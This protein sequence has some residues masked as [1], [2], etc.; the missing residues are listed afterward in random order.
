M[1]TVNPLAADLNH[2]LNH[3]EGLWD[4]FRG[5]HIFVTGGTG[6]F[7]CWLLE[8]FV[9][10]NDKLGL[11]SQAVVLTR[12]PEVFITKAPHLAKHPAIQLLKG[13]VRSFDFPP[14][15][16]SHVIHM[17]TESSQKLNIADPLLMLDT[18]IEGTR[19]VLDLAVRSKVHK[20]LLLSS[21]AVYGKQP[22][23]IT[24]IPET[25]AGAPDIFDIGMA[26]GQGKRIAEYLSVLYNNQHSLETK[27]ARGFTFVGPYLPLD[28][29]YAIGN[30]IGDVLNK[31]TIEVKGDGTPY[32]SY[33][34]AADAM[35]WLW[36]IL[37]NGKSC[38]PY[39]VGSERALTIAE[40][41]KQVAGTNKTALEVVI[42][43]KSVPGKPPE[44]YVPSTQRARTDLGLEQYIDLED[45][46]K[47]TI[48]WY[49][50]SENKR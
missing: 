2:I 33:L 1:V 48:R 11:N 47:R 46:I 20:F 30:F 37:C 40:L 21:G 25:Y 16:F 49:D 39:N 45:A 42:T 23:D 4:E 14:G 29:H 50:R 3:T 43:G 15:E 9:W 27:I 28:I 44:R 22:V 34:Y 24:R 19:H 18:I 35:I 8:S 31:R 26:Y 41:A 32:R 10:A 6:F 17:A 12:D 5:R 13:D 38:Y 36:T 7:G